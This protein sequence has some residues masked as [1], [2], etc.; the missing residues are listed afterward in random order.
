ML[1]I[2]TV[3]DSAGVV[4]PAFTVVTTLDNA[5]YNLSFHW[6]SRAA[7]W[8]FALASSDQTPLISS[9]AV[10]AN[11]ALYT[12]SVAGTPLGVFFVFDTSGQGLDPGREDLGKRVRVYF[13][14]PGDV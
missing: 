7:T 6:N 8:F 2:P 1:E 13:V 10:R 12:I 5:T 14:A 9:C 4:R 3:V 11:N